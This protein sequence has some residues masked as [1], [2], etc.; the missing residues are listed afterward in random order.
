[1]SLHFLSNVYENLSN[2]MKP[3]KSVTY[4]VDNATFTIKSKESQNMNVLHFMRTIN[5]NYKII[6]YTKFM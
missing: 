6:V 5:A 2:D 3:V 1:M 4:N